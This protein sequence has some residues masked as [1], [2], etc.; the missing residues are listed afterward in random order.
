MLIKNPSE[1]ERVARDW[2]VKFAGAP[3]SHVG[4]GSGNATK[5]TIEAAERENEERIMEA[6]LAEYA[7]YTSLDMSGTNSE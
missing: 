7:I 4:E 2:A 5:E 1:F 6:N 3:R